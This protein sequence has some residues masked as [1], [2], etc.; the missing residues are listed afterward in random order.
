MIMR[1]FLCLAVL[2][3]PGLAVAESNQEKNYWEYSELE[4]FPYYPEEFEVENGL[5]PM[6]QVAKNMEQEGIHGGHFI[7]S[8]FV[9]GG[10][11]L[12][13][14][15]VSHPPFLLYEDFDIGS[16]VVDGNH[17]GWK[18]LLKI[19]KSLERPASSCP[20]TCP[21]GQANVVARVQ[22]VCDFCK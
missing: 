14:Y 15:G 12:A 6:E 7:L 8:D 2:F 13:K 3:F 10:I 5:A 21:R 22:H 9:V 4:D 17:Y 18:D 11:N 1:I 16:Y 19:R 20:Y